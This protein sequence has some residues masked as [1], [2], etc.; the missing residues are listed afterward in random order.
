[1]IDES[2]LNGMLTVEAYSELA[3]SFLL[4]D[5]EVDGACKVLIIIFLLSCLPHF[6]GCS[7]AFSSV[8]FGVCC[9]FSLYRLYNFLIQLCS[10]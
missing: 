3:W 1:M 2:V 9:V 10:K 4:V 8:F 7:N 6:L 5:G